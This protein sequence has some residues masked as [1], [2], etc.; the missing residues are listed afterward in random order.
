MGVV[1]FFIMALALIT[2]QEMVKNPIILI[3]AGMLGIAT[4]VFA[5]ILD[6]LTT[7]RE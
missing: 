4:A 3:A 2:L 7:T 6:M 1:A 5:Y